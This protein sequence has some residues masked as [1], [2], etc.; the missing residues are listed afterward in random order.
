M[1][2]K[3]ALVAEEPA[4]SADLRVLRGTKDVQAIRAEVECSDGVEQTA[5]RAWRPPRP[6]RVF[7]RLNPSSR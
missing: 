4:D 6:P 2:G 5:T 7:Q 1:R 3:T